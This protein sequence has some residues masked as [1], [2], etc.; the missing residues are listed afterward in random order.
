MGTQIVCTYHKELQVRYDNYTFTFLGINEVYEKQKPPPGICHVL[1]H[2]LPTYNPFLHKRDVSLTSTYLHIYWNNLHASNTCIG[3]TRHDTLHYDSYVTL[4][5]TAIYGVLTQTPWSHPA[6]EPCIQSYN[7]F[8]KTTFS[9]KDIEGAPFSAGVLNIYPKPKFDK[10]CSWLQIFIKEKTYTDENA[11]ALFH[12]LEFVQGM[13]FKELLVGSTPTN[14]EL[15]FKQFVSN[16]AP[17]IH[18]RYIDNIT[19]EYPESDF[20]FYKS[21]CYRGTVLYSCQ[22]VCKQHQNGLYATCDTWTTPKQ[23]G[24]GIEAEDPRLV[25]VND[26]VYIVFISLSPYKAQTRCIGITPFET[27]NPT[28][29]HIE[30]L[31]PNPVEKNWSPFVIAN[32]LF[33][34]YS[35]DPLVILQY[36]FNKV[37]AC[38]VIFRQD[39]CVLPLN[40]SSFCLR[41]ST[42]LIPFNN[43]YYIGACHSNIVLD[44]LHFFTHIV[45]LDIQTW[46]IVY[47]S[48]PVLFHYTH[49]EACNAAMENHRLRGKLKP[50][51]RIGTVLMDSS[52]DYLQNPTSIF[53]KNEKCY[54]TISVRETVTLLYALEFDGLFDFVDSSKPVN[55]WDTFT[56]DT[57]RALI[58]YL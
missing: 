44:K 38:K 31:A 42:N 16:F 14:T 1:E 57:T 2:E 48:K 6:M 43:R 15:H 51:M 40:T 27:W 53:V 20:C 56:N 41:G 39:S 26:T 54:L 12:A 29:L 34:V 37:G 22:R 33:F 52:P 4:D 8:F 25:L 17:E 18:T 32:E 47:V 50:L 30:D 10:L 11:I 55:Y 7:M 9:F 23:Y 24:Y 28:F 21:Q 49:D 19:D 3:I 58:R 46:R 13:Q 36:D 35:Y 5:T 45:L